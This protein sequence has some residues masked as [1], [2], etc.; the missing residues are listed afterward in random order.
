VSHNK[1][2]QKAVRSE[3]LVL[4]VALGGDLAWSPPSAGQIAESAGRVPP[5]GG[6]TSGIFQNQMP[7][8][9]PFL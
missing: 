2:R 6:T 8:G 7:S 4:K 3:A 5:L 1:N 9:E